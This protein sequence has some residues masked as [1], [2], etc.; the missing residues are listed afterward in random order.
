M[1]KERGHIWTDNGHPFSWRNDFF[2]HLGGVITGGFLGDTGDVVARFF[3]AFHKFRFCVVPFGRNIDATEDNLMGG[4]YKRQGYETEGCV[5]KFGLRV[6][7]KMANNDILPIF[8][9]ETFKFFH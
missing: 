3:P 5:V 9:P 1:S 7:V 4:F 8:I 6:H 2:H